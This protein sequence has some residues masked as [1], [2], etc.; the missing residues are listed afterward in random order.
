MKSYIF[1]YEKKNDIKRH[2]EREKRGMSGAT[3]KKEEERKEEPNENENVQ[4]YSEALV[5]L[6]VI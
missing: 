2:I 4:G 6:S 5:T 3:K 1:E